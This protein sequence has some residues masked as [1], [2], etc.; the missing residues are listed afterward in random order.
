MGLN[1]LMKIG[2]LVY[3]GLA[4]L[5]SSKYNIIVNGTHTTFAKRWHNETSSFHFPISE[6]MITLEDAAC[7]L[8]LPIKGR[9]LDHSRIIRDEAVDVMVIYL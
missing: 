2:S 9:L 6:M 3:Y 8:H 5:C 7:L 1:N 4:Y